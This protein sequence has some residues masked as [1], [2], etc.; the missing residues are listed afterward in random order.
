MVF[1][2][3][4]G[5]HVAFYVGEDAQTFHTLGG[6][7]SDAVSI[8]RIDKARCVGMRWPAGKTLPTGG[9]VMLAADGT[10]V[11]KDEG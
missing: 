5:G 7:Q 9:P 11:S 3:P 6:N 2:R 10:A 1:T 8:T 4:Q